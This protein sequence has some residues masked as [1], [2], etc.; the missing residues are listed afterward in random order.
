MI[1]YVR[2][3]R[4]FLCGSWV[5]KLLVVVWSKFEASEQLIPRS[6]EPDVRHRCLYVDGK[7]TMTELYGK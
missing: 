7:Y 2:G 3:R 6:K 1:V 4:E 5:E